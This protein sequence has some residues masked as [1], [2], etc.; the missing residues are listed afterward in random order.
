MKQLVMVTGAAGQLGEAMS[1]QLGAR[2]E[3]T[4]VSIVPGSTLANADAALEAV[5]AICP[6]SSSIARRTRT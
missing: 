5:A 3:V 6:T 4:V 2:H 1:A